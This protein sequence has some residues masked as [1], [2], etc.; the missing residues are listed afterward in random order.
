ML[1]VKK[2]YIDSRL[3]AKDSRSSSDFVVDLPMNLSMPEN[4]VFYIDDVTIPVSWYNIDS[5]NNKLYIQFQ[6]PGLQTVDT[7]LTIPIGNYNVISLSQALEHAINVALDVANHPTL[8]VNVEYNITT[9]DIT[10]KVGQNNWLYNIWTDE[11]L[12]NREK[13]NRTPYQKP[14]NSI[15]AVLNYF[16]PQSLGIQTNFGPIDFNQV[17]NVYIH[18]PN[19]GTYSTLS[20]RGARDI[21]KKVPVNANANEIIFNNVMVAQDYL[22]CSRQTLSRLAFRLEDVYG[23]IINLHGNHWSF[24]IIFAKFDSEL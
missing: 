4:T 17:R 1:P 3:K 18:S 15:N 20:L 5:N 6:L 23:N 21:V 11:E 2:L 14:Y 12:D 19:L 13:E 9:N 8:S 16:I 24:S 10:I 7:V 22:D